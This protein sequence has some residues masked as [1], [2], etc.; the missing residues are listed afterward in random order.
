MNKIIE[1]P[2]EVI[3]VLSQLYGCPYNTNDIDGYIGHKGNV[4]ETLCLDGMDDEI[5]PDVCYDS[6]AGDRHIEVFEDGFIQGFFVGSEDE[7]RSKYYHILT[8]LQGI[9]LYKCDTIE[10]DIDK[11]TL[12][13]DYNCHH[14]IF[15]L[16][17]SPLKVKEYLKKRNG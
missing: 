2:S 4:I 6:W 13:V 10:L 8:K 15:S 1:N 14:F 7:P 16:I 12:S 3:S 11:F 5:L 9:T 17:V